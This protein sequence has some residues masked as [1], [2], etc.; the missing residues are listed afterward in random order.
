MVDDRRTE[1]EEHE[2]PAANVGDRTFRRVGPGGV[3]D[4]TAMMGTLDT[5]DTGAYGM[6]ALEDL[7]PIF[8][9]ARAH[10]MAVAARALDPEDDG[11]PEDQVQVSQGLTVVQGDP[12]GD[13]ARVRENARRAQT[14]LNEDAEFDPRFRAHYDR[15]AEA[16]RGWIASMADMR[17]AEV[18][19]V[20][21]VQGPPV[22]EEAQQEREEAFAEQQEAQQEQ[23]E[24]AQQEQEKDA[25]P[26]IPT[27][28]PQQRPA[29]EP[30]SSEN[31]APSI[32]PKP[33]PTEEEGE[34]KHTAADNPIWKATMEAAR[35]RSDEAK[36][37]DSA[38]AAPKKPNRAS[39]KHDWI[40][41]AL[42]VDPEL[43]RE[44]ASAMKREDLIET[45]GNKTR[46]NENK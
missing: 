1:E 32:E 28:V 40:D 39:S 22:T 10:D 45:Y 5:T 34:D 21:P 42:H 6:T 20:V 26:E 30:K 43:S 4:H 25:E 46:P 33:S 23:Q 16:E 11:V 38:P 14:R 24:E 2:A 12:E 29:S 44:Q 18:V 19:G 17:P 9:V 15:R 31:V 13:R 3:L 27:T 8:K 36:E 41:W 35:R 7:A 37:R